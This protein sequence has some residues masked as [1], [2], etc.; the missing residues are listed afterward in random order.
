MK[1]CCTVTPGTETPGP[2]EENVAIMSLASEAPA[3]I[4]RSESPGE[5]AEPQLEPGPATGSAL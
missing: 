3:E 2:R 4:T 1:G 5:L